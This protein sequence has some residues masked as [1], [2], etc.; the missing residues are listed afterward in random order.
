MMLDREQIMA[1]QPSVRTV[2][3]VVFSLIMCVVAFLI[4]VTVI[5]DWASV[6]TEFSLLATVSLVFGILMALMSIVVAMVVWHSALQVAL[7]HLKETGTDPKEILGMRTLVG[8]F[9]SKTIIQYAIIESAAFFCLVIFLIDHS[10]VSL[11]TAVA[12]VLMM[13]VMFPT[14]SRILDRVDAIISQR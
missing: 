5:A 13:I 10:M 7:T 1:L 9:Q 2:Q 12:L 14:S 6:N 4:M 8:V 3:I 11:V